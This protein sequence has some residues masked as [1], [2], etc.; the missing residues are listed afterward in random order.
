MIELASHQTEAVARILALLDRYG[1]AILADDVGL[2]KSFVA[3][4]VAAE[5]RARRCLVEI[6]VPASLV[7]Q[8][9]GTLADFQVDARTITHDSLIADCFVAAATPRFIVV[10]EAHAFRNPRTQRYAALARCS[11]GARLL[12]V[13]ATPVC[14]S[15]DDLLALVAL[16]TADDA[17][18]WRGVASIGDVFAARDAP[19]IDAIVSELVIRRERDV[20]PD[21]LRFGELERRVVRHSVLDLPIDE[22]QFPLAGSASLL[23]QFV[24]RRLESSHAALIESIRRQLRFYERV[25]ESGR[26]LSRRD[27]RRAFGHEVESDAFQQILFWNLWA[28]QEPIDLATVDAE[29]ARLAAL[30]TTVER[31]PDRK[32][33]LLADA[34]TAEPTLVFTGAAATARD[35]ARHFRCGLA[36]SRNGIGAVE[37]FRRGAIDLLVATDLASEGLNLQRA[38][39]VVHYDIPWNPVKLDQRNGRAHRIGQRRPLVHAVYFLPERDRTRVLP[40]VAAKNR[41]RRRVLAPRFVIAQADSTL[42]LPQHLPPDA[43]AVALLRA[44]R[45]RGLASPPALPRRHRAGV[46]RLIEE[47][48][49]EYLDEERVREL[50]EVLKR[51]RELIGA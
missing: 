40:I 21:A 13:T 47:M 28:A 6:I 4:A 14:N 30:R 17:L 9:R 3:A 16:V 51:E 41:T 20:L 24:W 26:P 22:L 29:M 44:L 42:A 35:L 25:V 27:Y 34:L 37:A 45:A 2:G 23:R 18:R 31:A 5:M 15:A 38:G 32:R 50:E 11:I 10:D 12:L 43:A 48:A 39:V 8:W 33:L 49:R 36:T 1:G 19:A 46:E 7:A